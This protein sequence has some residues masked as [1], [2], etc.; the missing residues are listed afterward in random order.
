MHR[1]APLLAGL[2][3]SSLTGC[4]GFGPSTVPRDRFDYVST[5]SDSWKSQMLL[6]IV[7]LRYADVPSFLDV[8]S[9]ISQYEYAAEINASWGWDL[10]EPGSYSR[11]LGGAGRYAERP[12]ITY[13]PIAGAKFTQSLM[14]PVPPSAVLFLLQAGYPVRLVLG[15]CVRT[16]NDLD[17]RSLDPMWARAAD[18][19]F[20]RLLDLL[21]RMQRAG[22]LAMRIDKA[23]AA[24]AIV[25]AVRR[26][27][28]SA[29]DADEVARLLGLSRGAAE[30]QVTYGA[31]ARSNREI[32]IQTRSIFE[33][34]IELSARVQPPPEH[35]SKGYVSSVRI[36]S[37]EQDVPFQ[38][39]SG[40]SEP[41]EAYTAVPYLGHWFWIAQ[42]DEASK[43]D[44][45]FLMLLFS[46]VEP[47]EG[48]TTP[49]VT[50][51]AS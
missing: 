14:T 28:V 17:N 41:G 10:P 26:K 48:P 22:G 7:K 47:S 32:A 8:G 4:V 29:H 36:D 40:K 3:A 2:L 18:P 25:M 11:S 30:Y 6:N 5:I 21:E 31:V 50:V 23:D 46:L 20:E 12:T 49:I 19:G 1:L 27:R 38:V 43:V 45:V 42:H 13:V 37:G 16:I 34:M 35:V 39:L 33:I 15:M 9:V 51:P 24:D 44:F